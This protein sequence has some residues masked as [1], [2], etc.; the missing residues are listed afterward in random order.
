M[1]SWIDV[2]DGSDFSI[3]N[4][5]LGVMRRRDGAVC[6]ATAIGDD[7]LDL[8]VLTAA[9]LLA[10]VPGADADVMSSTSLNALLARGP[11]TWRALRARLT[12]LLLE[13]NR[14][15]QGDQGIVADAR[16][17]RHDVEMLLPVECGDFVDFFA[18]IHHVTN[19]GRI[20]Q[21]LA[22]PLPP[23]WRSVPIGYHSRTGSLVADGA[24]ITRPHGVTRDR[25]GH[26]SY[27]P[28]RRL[29]FEL[30]VGFVVGTS[31]AP[32]RAVTPADAADVV[33]GAVLVNDWSARDVQA[34]E[35][36]PLGPLQGKSFATSMSSWVVPLDALAPFACAGPVQDPPPLPHLRVDGPSAIDLELEVS[37]QSSSM[38]EANAPPTVVA[39]TSFAE[40]YWTMPQLLAHLTSN[41]ASVRT[42]DLFASGTVSG[43]A[44]GSEGSIT[45][46][47][48]AGKEPIVLP[49][50]EAR[51][52]LEDGDQVVFR[53]ACERA[54]RPRVGFGE[55]RGTITPAR[56]S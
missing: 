37:L 41:G 8:S 56:V 10:D 47:T 21:P 33:F 54:A 25:E 23:A 11:G 51:R 43:A 7:A 44:R 49:G 5:P 19:M 39:R 52:Y 18:S 29:D 6:V 30:E 50:G 28:T 40:M 26:V 17:S 36:K 38:R 34:F 46:L 15:L 9:G 16:V 27:G 48:A 3:A 1:R 12:E 20:L 13:G 22:D 35:S 42:G 24:T 14:E 31:T 32:G 53:G 2:P 4:L 55:L 45:E